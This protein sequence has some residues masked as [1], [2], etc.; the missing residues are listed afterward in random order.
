[1][2]AGFAG[3]RRGQGTF[4]DRHAAR[5]KRLSHIRHMPLCR[6]DMSGILDIKNTGTFPGCHLGL[7]PTRH[8]HGENV[9]ARNSLAVVAHAGPL[10]MATTLSPPHALAALAALGSADPPADLSDAD[11]RRAGR[12]SRGHDR[13]GDRMSAQHA[14]FAFAHS[15]PRRARARNARWPLDRL[16]R[17]CR[18]HARPSVVSRQRLLQRPSGTMRVRPK[19]AAGCGCGPPPRPTSAR[20]DP[21]ARPDNKTFQRPVSLHRQLGPLDHG[22]GHHE[23]RSGEANFTPIR[24]EASPRARFTDMRS[25]SCAS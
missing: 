1:M 23:P 25:I 8:R 11:A 2:I 5:L 22:R 20:G 16:S 19:P 24:P 3:S 10:P 17:R 4:R 7:V 21:C 18:G 13:R 14:V 12:A 6:L 15:R 9:M